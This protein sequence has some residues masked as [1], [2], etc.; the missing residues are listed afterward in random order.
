MVG[1]KRNNKGQGSPVLSLRPD[2]RKFFCSQRRNIT[3]SSTQA[4]GTPAARTSPPRPASQPVPSP[5]RGGTPRA[6]IPP[7]RGAGRIS[8]TLRVTHHLFRP[9]PGL[10]RGPEAL[11]KGLRVGLPGPLDLGVRGRPPRVKLKFPKMFPKMSLILVSRPRPKLRPASSLRA[12]MGALQLQ[13]R[14]LLPPHR[15]ALPT[16]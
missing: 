2:V 9:S 6:G 12:E 15:L 11:R 4:P 10:R 7:R 5:P 13:L 14:V 1:K 8:E 16:G 3:S